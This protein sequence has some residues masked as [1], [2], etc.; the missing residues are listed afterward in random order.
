MTDLVEQFTALNSAALRRH[1]ELSVDAPQAQQALCERVAADLEAAKEVRVL[2]GGARAGIVL[3]RSTTR[4]QDCA[5]HCRIDIALDDAEATGWVATQMREL[6]PRFDVSFE[7]QLDVGH[8]AL[9]PELQRCGLTPRM[10][11]LHGDPQAAL[12]GLRAGPL[13]RAT[14]S[15]D[16]RIEALSQARH[17]EPIVTLVRE[18][19]E[20][21]PG[22]GPL[23]PHVSITAAVQA[24]LDEFTRDSLNEALGKNTTLVVLRDA[25][26]MGYGAYHPRHDPIMGHFAGLALGFD[27]SIQGRGLSKLVYERLLERMIATGVQ[28]MRGRT[29]N[30]AVL[31]LAARMKRPL[32]GWQL[33]PA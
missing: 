8:R 5:E 12:D 10:K 13:N 7:L 27:P 9:L 17:V 28:L 16:L 19:F 25:E 31:H 18:Y 1:P 3:Y 24:R 26:V 33:E 4:F 29:A 30:L 23:S 20:R 11:W 21:D 6:A 32:R 14:L 15:D 2:E 22:T